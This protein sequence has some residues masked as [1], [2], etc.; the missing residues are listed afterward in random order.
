[1]TP[2]P[3]WLTAAWQKKY[4]GYTYTKAH[5]GFLAHLWLCTTLQPVPVRADKSFDV[6]LTH[7]LLYRLGIEAVSS[8]VPLG[9]LSPESIINRFN[10]IQAKRSTE[11]VDFHTLPEIIVTLTGEYNKGLSSKGSSL[12]DRINWLKEERTD[13]LKEAFHKDNEIL[14]TAYY[15]DVEELYKGGKHLSKSSHKDTKVLPI[16]ESLLSQRVKKLQAV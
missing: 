12:S 15:T 8:T 2:V 13:S 1:M 16:K 6:E 5:E 11:N 3:I 10:D 7:Y 9:L 4:L 14:P